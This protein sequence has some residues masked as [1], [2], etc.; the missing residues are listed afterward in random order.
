[1]SQVNNFNDIVVDGF[2][3]YERCNID[4]FTQQIGF[5]FQTL[6]GFLNLGMNILMKLAVDEDQ[7]WHNTYVKLLSTD[8]LTCA[9]GFGELWIHVF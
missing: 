3:L 1:M 8:K 7:A 2:D 6:S 5:Y 9:A 4:F